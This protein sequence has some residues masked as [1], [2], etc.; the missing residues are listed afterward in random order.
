V[1]E[2]TKREPCW[3][4]GALHRRLTL[5]PAKN[6]D[7][8]SGSPGDFPTSESRTCEQNKCVNFTGQSPNL[9]QKMR[10]TP[11]R[12]QP[13]ASEAPPTVPSTTP[14]SPSTTRTLMA[15]PQPAVPRATRLPSA[16]GSRH[17]KAG[18]GN[19]KYSPHLCDC[20]G[21]DNANDC[22]GA[23][24]GTFLEDSNAGFMPSKHHLDLLDETVRA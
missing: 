20:K 11:Q 18:Q 2:C 9:T 3:L 21:P 5:R 17:K 4:H 12:G 8:G 16:H 1:R 15:S 23:R 19:K 10:P 14:R 7:S 6:I 13:T 22:A 24:L